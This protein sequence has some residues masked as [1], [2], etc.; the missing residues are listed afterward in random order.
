MRG[1]FHTFQNISFHDSTYTKKCPYI[2]KLISQF[3]GRSLKAE[4]SWRAW[5]NEAKVNVN[6][7]TLRVEQNVSIVPGKQSI[8]RYK[9]QQVLHINPL[10]HKLH[11]ANN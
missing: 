11:F 2:Y 1:T 8:I 10:V 9:I 3:E 6:N 7:M 4:V 5:Q